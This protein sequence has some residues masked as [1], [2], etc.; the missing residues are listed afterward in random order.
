[1]TI[2]NMAIQSFEKGGYKLV[3]NNFNNQTFKA[4]N[5]ENQF[6]VH[7]T[8][9]TENVQRTYKVQRVINYL[10]KDTN[11]PVSQPITQTLTFIQTGVKDLVTGQVDWNNIP[12]QTFDEVV[13]PLIEGY[14]EPSQKVIETEEV[15]FD[16]DNITINVY[17]TKKPT[18]SIK[19][20]NITNTPSDTPNTKVPVIT[21]VVNK[22]NNTVSIV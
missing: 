18:N 6:E 16:S 9:N 11:T 3:S 1:M 2:P 17:Y 7:F 10:D 12:T 22:N 15:N 4:D 8:H 21:N 20:P 14:N 5:D 13:S 19:V